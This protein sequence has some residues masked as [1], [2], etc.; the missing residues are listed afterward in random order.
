MGKY[1]LLLALCCVA[2]LGAPVWGYPITGSTY[3]ADEIVLLPVVPTPNYTNY[4]FGT[5]DATGTQGYDDGNFLDYTI[6]IEN[7]F[8]QDA[9]KEILFDLS[10]IQVEFDSWLEIH[11]DF[12]M[13]N[14]AWENDPQQPQFY[15]EAFWDVTPPAQ[16]PLDWKVV[17]FPGNNPNA[18]LK[19]DPLD[20]A[21]A[22]V[23]LDW[24]LPPYD[25][26]S[27]YDWN[28]EWAS[29]E[30]YGYGFS[31]DYELTDWCV[32]EPA[33]LSLLALGSLVFCRRRRS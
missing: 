3:D 8:R 30:F 18:P 10:N 21:F 1:R 29:L 27:Y 9:W 16:P 13:T 22:D 32:P 33:T 11:V 24:M 2:L 17:G 4:A 12:S 23:V 26:S 20:V 14:P 15:C 19:L 7:I 25:G 31:L 6:V 28:P 5:I